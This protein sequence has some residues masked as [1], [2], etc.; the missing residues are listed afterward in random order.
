MKTLKENICIPEE[1]FLLFDELYLQNSE[2]YNGGKTTEFL[3]SQRLDNAFDC[4][5][6]AEF[7]I[8]H[9]V[10]TNKRSTISHHAVSS[11]F[12]WGTA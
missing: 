8:V 9:I 6:S 3:R 12:D 11:R 4:S 5:K 2:E 1:A 7:A 10:S